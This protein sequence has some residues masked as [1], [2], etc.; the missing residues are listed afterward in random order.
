VAS[1]TAMIGAAAK[2][3]ETSNRPKHHVQQ[4]GHRGASRIPDGEPPMVAE[5]LQRLHRFAALQ[6]D[7]RRHQQR[8]GR[9]IGRAT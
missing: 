5:D 8:A 3:T 1:I 6:L 7:E 4:A 9:E 2:I